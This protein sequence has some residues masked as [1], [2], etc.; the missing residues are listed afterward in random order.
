[1]LGA[2]VRKASKAMGDDTTL[3]RF[4][5]TIGTDEKPRKHRRQQRLPG[6]EPAFVLEGRTK[7]GKS[8]KRVDRLKNLLVSGTATSKSA[9]KREY[10]KWISGMN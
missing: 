2:G 8:V 3:T 7:F 5:K 1:M 9:T 4:V 10:K 6:F